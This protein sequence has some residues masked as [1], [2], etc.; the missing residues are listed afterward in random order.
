MPR[1]DVSVSEPPTPTA[2]APGA[3]KVAA[4]VDALLG[5]L[6]DMLATKR[7]DKAKAAKKAAPKKAA[8]AKAG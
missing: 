4:S 2:V 3:P 5:A 6:D 8:A 1:P 7:A